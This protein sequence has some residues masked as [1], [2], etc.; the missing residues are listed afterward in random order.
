MQLLLGEGSAPG[1][2]ILFGEHAVVY[3]RPALAAP[4]CQVRALVEVRAGVPGSGVTLVSHD[5]DETISLRNAAGDHPLALAARLALARLELEEPDWQLTIASSIPIA[6]G[7]GSGAAVS[8]A[9]IRAVAN[10]AGQRLEAFAVSELV[11]EVEKLHHGTPSGIDNTVIAFGQPIY[12]VRGSAPQHFE[13]AKPFMLAI[14]DTGVRSPTRVSV[15]AVRQAWQERP[16]QLEAAFDRIAAIVEA[17][18]TA[19]IAGKPEALGPLMD[20]NQ[21]ELRGLDVS[22]PLLDSLAAAAKRAGALGAK[23]SGAGRGG[24]LIALVTADSAA[25][26][27]TRLR[28][29]GAVRAFLSWIGGLAVDP[30]RGASSTQQ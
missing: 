13:I 19:I 10:A 30:A 12:Y 14:A 20:E 16:E 1:K 22:S 2:V 17:G 8:A 4:V 15:G 29:A 6:S 18:R 27:A 25:A 7:L 24:N 23:L 11:Y 5:L 9:I 3:G 26:V 21:N 28:E